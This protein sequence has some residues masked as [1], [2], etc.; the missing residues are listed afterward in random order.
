MANRHNRHSHCEHKVEFC[1][2]CDLVYCTKCSHEWGAACS[3][4]HYPYAWYSNPWTISPTT[5]ITW[6]AA[7]GTA[8]EAMALGSDGHVHSSNT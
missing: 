5:T 7:G 4:N 3:L 2:H 6:D 8:A 1:D